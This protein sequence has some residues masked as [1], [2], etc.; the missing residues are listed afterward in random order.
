MTSEAAAAL[1]KVVEDRLKVIN[2]WAAPGVG[3]STQAAALFNLM[4][5]Q[6]FSVEL[7]LEAAKGM[8]YEHAY[9]RLSNQTLILAKQE[10]QLHR[11]K[12][13]VE[14]V[15]TDSPFPLGMAYAAD[16]SRYEQL[17]DA[18]WDDYDNYSF[19]LERDP[20]R[21]YVQSGRNETEEQ[22]KALDG[23]IWDLYLQYS[24]GEF[25]PI[26]GNEFDTEYNILNTVLRAQG[27][28][29]TAYGPQG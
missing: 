15:I 19:Y 13:E 24:E 28:P 14:Y 1:P 9:K 3:K 23:P 5:L 12:G 4:K 6:G 8:T 26:R 7:I 22:S 10:H 18:L 29:E 2:L 16:P 11:L 25:D 21:P 20:N 17:I 27:L